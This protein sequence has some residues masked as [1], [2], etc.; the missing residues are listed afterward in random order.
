MRNV[1]TAAITPGG[2]THPNPS[3]SLPDRQAKPRPGKHRPQ[4][5][6][7]FQNWEV[8]GMTFETCLETPETRTKQIS[9]LDFSI[10]I[11]QHSPRIG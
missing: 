8:Q 9:G 7:G 1:P 10:T 6:R 3:L 11:P 4:V 5:E 2:R